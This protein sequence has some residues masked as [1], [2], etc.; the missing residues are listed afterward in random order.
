MLHGTSAFLKHYVIKTG[1]L[2]GLDGL[3]LSLGKALASY[4][5][6]ARAL[7]IRRAIR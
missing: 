5:K 7:E 6:Y 4:L 1:F 2:A 3:T